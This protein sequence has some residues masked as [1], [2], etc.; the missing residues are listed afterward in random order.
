MGVKISIITVCY[1]A[2]EEIE[3]TICSVL[4]QEFFDYEYIIQDGKS[5]DNTMNVVRKHQKDFEQ[6]KIDYKIYTQ[7]DNGVYD[8]MNIAGLKASGEFLI[9]L[10][11]GD[12]LA[13]NKVFSKFDILQRRQK[14]DVYFGDT[15][16][17]NNCG[18]M[19]FKA[20][21]NLISRRMPFSHQACFIKR[22]RFLG[23][24]Y[25]CKY[26]ICGDYDLILRLYEKRNR[27]VPL[28][29]IVCKYDMNGISSTQF[30]NKRKEHEEILSEHNLNNTL[31][32]S[33]HIIAAWIKEFVYHV[34]PEKKLVYMSR[35][36]M[37]KIKHYEYW[38]GDIY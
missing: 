27:F 14:A 9:F 20:D 1:N 34:I 16:M 3:A 5:Q 29:T 35:F 32:K 11:A 33:I 21:L 2:Q 28:N 15:L 6:K 18:T 17:K 30:I 13:H 26:K 23:E 7:T 12:V 8:A 19:L 31:K 37:R 22:E 10:N 24:L 38:E 36:Y 4:N 25:N